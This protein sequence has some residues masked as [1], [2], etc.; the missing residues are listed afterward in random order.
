MLF[1]AAAW[2]PNTAAR[3]EPQMYIRELLAVSWTKYA[4]LPILKQTANQRVEE[5][6]RLTE[7]G[8]EKDAKLSRFLQRSLEHSE[9][10]VRSLS[11]FLMN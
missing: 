3:F 6:M 11:L 1:V 9:T 4:S 10:S 5:I 7:L 8:R 2:P